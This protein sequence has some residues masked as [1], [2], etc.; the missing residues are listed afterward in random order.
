MVAVG[1]EREWKILQGVAGKWRIVCR[2]ARFCKKNQGISK[3]QCGQLF[4]K[5]LLVKLPSRKK[6]IK[7]SHE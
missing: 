2:I 4:G 6:K 5:K 3:I 7:G 1:G